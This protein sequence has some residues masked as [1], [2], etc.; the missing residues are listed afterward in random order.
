MA[1]AERVQVGSETIQR[2]VSAL[3]W[4]TFG[5]SRRLHH[6]LAIPS[7][8]SVRPAA[9]CVIFDRVWDAELLD[10]KDHEDNILRDND[11]DG[12]AGHPAAVFGVDGGG[13]VGVR[14]GNQELLPASV[15]IFLLI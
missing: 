5:R 12:G 14:L 8:C 11:I 4:T 3:F 10:R 13:G 9:N 15:I 1:N 6:V 7:D 2:M